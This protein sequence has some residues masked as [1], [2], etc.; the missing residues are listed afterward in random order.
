MAQRH[1]SSSVA[2]GAEPSHFSLFLVFLTF[3][4]L[5]AARVQN[6]G[7]L[8]YQKF[9]LKHTIKR[10]SEHAVGVCVPMFSCT[11]PPPAS[12]SQ[13]R[14]SRI[15]AALCF[16]ASSHLTAA[17]DFTPPDKNHVKLLP[18]RPARSISRLD[19]SHG[20]VMWAL[21]RAGPASSH[22][23]WILF[24]VLIRRGRLTCKINTPGSKL[25]ASQRTH[26]Y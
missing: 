25:L 5:S 23:R 17:D 13:Q 8:I 10:F 6:F 26:S 7:L 12:G 22:R 15:T 2:C 24:E 19:R 20:G 3:C 21:F 11:P 16:N 14:W 4:F 18:V 9:H 1:D